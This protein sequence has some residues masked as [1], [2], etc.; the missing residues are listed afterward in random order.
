MVKCIFR[1][2]A[3]TSFLKHPMFQSWDPEVLDIHIVNLYL[4]IFI[5]CI[6]Y[7]IDLITSIRNMVYV[8]HLMDKLHSNV[9][10]YKNT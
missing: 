8:K 9:P 7:L 10:N 6:M 3:K 1:N 2:I 5:L 4:F